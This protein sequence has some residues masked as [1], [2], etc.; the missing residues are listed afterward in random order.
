M[1][2]VVISA[3]ATGHYAYFSRLP[4]RNKKRV[5]KKK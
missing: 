3:M 4:K 2:K 1:V 5:E